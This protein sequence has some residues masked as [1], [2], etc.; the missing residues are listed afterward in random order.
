MVKTY[1]PIADSKFKLVHI[2]N[3]DKIWPE[4]SRIFGGKV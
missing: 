3:K 2:P 1:A 4:F